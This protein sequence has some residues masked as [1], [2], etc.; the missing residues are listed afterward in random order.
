VTTVTADAAGTADAIIFLIVFLGVFGSPFVALYFVPTIVGFR[1]K[2][3]NLRAVVAINILLGWTLVGWFVA[4]VMARSRPETLQ[5]DNEPVATPTTEA[6]PTTE[7]PSAAALMPS[8]KVGKRWGLYLGVSI[9]VT[10]LALM[11]L[12]FVDLAANWHGHRNANGTWTDPW[13]ETCAMNRTFM[14]MDDRWCETGHR[15]ADGTWT[16]YVG[17]TCAINRTYMFKKKARV[18][19]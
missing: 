10:L 9:G 8:R 4:L 1:N 15:N 5:A 18:C 3:P 7:A 13:R 12:F 19:S 11:A 16:D 6:Q 17:V 14:N 2:V